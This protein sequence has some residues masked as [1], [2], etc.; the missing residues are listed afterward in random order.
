MCQKLQETRVCACA[1]RYIALT[2]SCVKANISQL[3]TFRDLNVIAEFGSTHKGFLDVKC[4]SFVNTY[5]VKC[6]I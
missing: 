3:N 5:L 2:S 1:H 4:P 6:K